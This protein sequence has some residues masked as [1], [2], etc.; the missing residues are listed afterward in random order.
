MCKKLIYLISFILILG[1][2]LINEAN[3]QDENLVGWWKLDDMSGYIAH[4]SS[5]NEL[6]GILGSEPSDPEWAI[7]YFGGSLEFE[8]GDYV[9]L[10][11]PDELNFGTNDWTLS[12]WINSTAPSQGEDFLCPIIGNG[13][14][15]TGGIR[16][17]VTFNEVTE[18]LITVTTDDDVD[19][20]QVTGTVI[21]ND[22]V[23]HHIA[24]TREG[25]TLYLYIDG[26]PDGNNPDLPAGYDLSG[27][28]QHNAYIGTITDH[29]DNALHKFYRDGR[30][31]DVRIFNVALTED[32]IAAV[33]SYM[34]EDPSLAW[35]A[36]PITGQ[37]DV[38][39]DVVLSWKAGIYAETHNVYFGTV[40]DDV[41]EA[42][43]DDMRGVLLS[44]NLAELTFDPPGNLDL[45]KI[46]YWRVDEV[47][48][49][50][51]NSPWKGD[52]WSFTAAN[53]TIVDDFEDY[54]DVDNKIYDTWTDYFMNN[55]GM[56]VGH[57][58]PPFT[59]QR[60]VHTGSQS[61]YMC[62]DN[63]GTV[64]EGTNYERSGT[65]LYSEANREW[66][67]PQDWTREGFNSL[68]L[69][70]RGV[71][72]SVG[73]F[74]VGSSGYTMTGAGEDIWSVADGFHFAYKRL[75][76]AGSI[77]AKVLSISDTDQWAKAG[78]MIRQS[79]EPGSTHA[80]MVITP[81]NGVSFQRR[82][83]VNSGSEGTD[84]ADITAPQ[85][86]RLIRSGNT[87]TGQ[88]SDNGSTWTTL[89]SVDMP[90]LLDV[91]IG[92]CLTSHNVDA[93]C[94]AEFSDVTT[95]G[96]GEWQS[97]DIG[98]E[99]NI[100]EP[101]YVVLEDNTGSSAVVKNSD[102][103]ATAIGSWTEWN[104]PLT[105]FAGVN[106]QAV[107]SMV[108]GVGD[109]ANPQAGSAGKLYIDDIWLYIP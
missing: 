20:V 49:T 65:L 93:M 84:Q 94:T 69:W 68:T 4:D 91:Y 103:A 47:N 45:G 82:T 100:P 74:T 34:R 10:G 98:I 12:A 31:D 92:L 19:K 48:D 39:Q 99:S 6:H 23:W 11:N 13:G 61:M 1:L 46:Y 35:G 27:T 63:D 71:S 70:F 86:V 58:E 3:A 95:D 109:R 2:V 66:V 108:I 83:A 77:T 90:M 15:W 60:I 79:L 21:V 81:G 107:K 56:T 85:W 9:D 57:F 62:Y 28:S 59:E 8:L 96:T 102:P 26:V 25:T 17:A 75:S 5:G 51:P 50:E 105:D 97:Q 64:N 29:R 54:N 89:G 53:F 32:E 36:N 67:D 41:N 18:G 80:M 44:Q 14:D 52:I 55:T 7:G 16:Y 24:V 76:G 87:F 73:S 78:V 33:M 43:V 22:G 42:S 88:Y 106:M 38:L 72:A 30:I 101:M 40:F 104:I 37:I